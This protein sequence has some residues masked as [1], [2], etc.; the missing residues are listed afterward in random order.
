V[1]W[2]CARADDVRVHVKSAHGLLGLAEAAQRGEDEDFGHR[3]L[4]VDV[5]DA[6]GKRRLALLRLCRQLGQ[7]EPHGRSDSVHLR[8][9][10]HLELRAAAHKGS[11]CPKPHLDRL[12]IA[13]DLLVDD[14]A[15]RSDAHELLRAAHALC[16][17][18][19]RR[20]RIGIPQ[21]DVTPARSLEM[22]PVRRRARD[23]RAGAERRELGD[24][25]DGAEERRPCEAEGAALREE[26]SRFDVGDG[27]PE[28]L[29]HL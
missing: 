9:E 8:V 16:V 27:E 12:H 3:L 5:A 2:I 29:A 20:D 1:L 22:S 28:E 25:G 19:A 4:A 26:R 6:L 7:I 14:I 13:C 11:V 10:T 23:V 15:P 17:V 24:A 18:Q 21:E